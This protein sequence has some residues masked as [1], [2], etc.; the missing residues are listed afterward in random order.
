MVDVWVQAT[1]AVQGRVCSLRISSIISCHFSRVLYWE[2]LLFLLTKR[3]RGH[4]GFQKQVCCGK[5]R[6]WLWRRR[7]SLASFRWSCIFYHSAHIYG[8]LTSMSLFSFCIQFCYSEASYLLQAESV[9]IN[10]IL[11]SV[12][13]PSLVKFFDGMDDDGSEFIMQYSMPFSITSYVCSFYHFLDSWLQIGNSVVS[14][15][16]NSGDFVKN[17]N[18]VRKTSNGNQNPTRCNQQTTREVNVLSKENKT[19]MKEQVVKPNNKPS[20]NTNSGLLR[21]QKLST[22]Q[23]DNHEK[24]QRKLEKPTIPK[25]NQQDVSTRISRS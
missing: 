1:A 14:D 3:C 20:S 13:I 17:R 24:F 7:P 11:L 21:Q 18:N 19:Q 10:C 5:R 15:P 22:E 23:K 25:R 16:R 8:A 2:M 12:P 9:L 6:R 4:T